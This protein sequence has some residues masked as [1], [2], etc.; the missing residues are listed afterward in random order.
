MSRNIR[1]LR[2]SLALHLDHRS[3]FS[4]RGPGWYL[5]ARHSEGQQAVVNRLRIDPSDALYIAQ[6]IDGLGLDTRLRTVVADANDTARRELKRLSAQ[7]EEAVER[8]RRAAALAR[9]FEREDCG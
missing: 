4:P 6:S 3:D 8:A 7:A 5:D 2:I 1:D 9:E